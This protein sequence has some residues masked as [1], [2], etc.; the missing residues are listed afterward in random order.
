[1]LIDVQP[2]M[3]ALIANDLLG[4]L[5][6]DVKVSIASCFSEII[7]ITAPDTLYND[8]IMKEIFRPIVGDFKNLDE[9]SR[10]S[11]S[12]RVS[13]LETVAKVRSSI[14]MLDL[15]C[16]DLIFEMSKHSD[17]VFSSMETMTLILEETESISA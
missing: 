9:I 1:M 16:N 7:R 14:L 13:I 3:K 5:D 12:K 11:F 15:D 6:M 17:I 8:D 4:Y 10:C 2:T